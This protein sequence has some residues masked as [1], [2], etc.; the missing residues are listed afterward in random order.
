MADLLVK[1]V[2]IGAATY[3]TKQL[4]SASSA[5]GV[6]GAVPNFSALPAQLR[7]LLE[8][9]EETSGKLPDYLDTT[10]PENRKWVKLGM[11]LVIDLIGSGSLPVPLLADALDL[12]WAPVSALC[13]HALFGNALITAAGFAEEFL[14]GTD[15]VPTATLAWVNEHYGDAIRKV[16]KEASATDV[17]AK[18]V[19]EKRNPFRRASSRREK[20]RR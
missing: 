10:A 9:A 2:E 15:G 19:Q 17:P 8:A 14:P 12:A 11:C 3:A 1:A 5:E 7:G 18:P 20:A 16:V 13:L 4:S 6:R